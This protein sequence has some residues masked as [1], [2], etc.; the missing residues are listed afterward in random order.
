MSLYQLI[1]YSYILQ[2]EFIFHDPD[3]QLGDAITWIRESMKMDELI[4]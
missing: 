2:C 4:K 1:E 3:S